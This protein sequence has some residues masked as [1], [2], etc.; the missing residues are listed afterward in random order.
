MWQFTTVAISVSFKNIMMF[1]S[2]L[3]VAKIREK[4]VSADTIGNLYG[5]LLQ[6]S[7]QPR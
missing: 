2:E 7:W 5:T 1:I 3:F 6:N 4:D